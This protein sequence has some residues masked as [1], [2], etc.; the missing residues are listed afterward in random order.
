M[1]DIITTM[2][3]T[4]KALQEQFNRIPRRHSLENV[5]DKLKND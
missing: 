5:K 3:E 2:N 1:P 4:G